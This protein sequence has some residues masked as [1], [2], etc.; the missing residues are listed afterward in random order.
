MHAGIIA[1]YT[2]SCHHVDADDN[3]NNDHDDHAYPLWP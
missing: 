3:N 1:A 2:G